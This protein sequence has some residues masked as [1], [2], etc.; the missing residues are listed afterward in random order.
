LDNQTAITDAA[1]TKLAV[2]VYG[3]ILA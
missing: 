1:N 3:H 2:F